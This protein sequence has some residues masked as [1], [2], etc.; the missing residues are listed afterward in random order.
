MNMALKLKIIE[1]FKTQHLFSQAV[2]KSESYVSYVINGWKDI[3]DKEKKRWAKKLD[4]EVT[5]FD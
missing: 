1:K 3:D 5:I 4:V 2:K